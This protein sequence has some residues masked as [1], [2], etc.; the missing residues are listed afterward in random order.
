MQWT[1]QWSLL[2]LFR[3]YV[4]I[5]YDEIRLHA[6]SKATLVWM[7]WFIP[8]ETYEHG[9]SCIPLSHANWPNMLQD[10]MLVTI[11]QTNANASIEISAE[12]GVFNTSYMCDYCDSVVLIPGRVKVTAENTESSPCRGEMEI[13]NPWWIWMNKLYLC[14]KNCGSAIPTP[15][16]FIPPLG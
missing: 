15:G 1:H 8:V 16:W 14:G 9:A 13:A 3:S 10:C 7:Q 12:P 5:T 4:R 2:F 6:P 11:Y